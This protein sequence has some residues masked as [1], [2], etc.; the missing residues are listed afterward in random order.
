MS[1]RE[2]RTAAA[3]CAVRYGSSRVRSWAYRRKASTTVGSPAVSA[4]F[5]GV[6]SRSGGRWWWN[7]EWYCITGRNVDAA[8]ART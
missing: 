5:H 1:G 7:S 8:T 6:R 4:T 2:V 3:A